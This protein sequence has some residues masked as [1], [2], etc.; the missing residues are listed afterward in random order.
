[1]DIRTLLG[2]SV[3]KLKNRGVSS[4][5]LD[6]ELLLAQ[7]LAKPKEY[8]HTYPE[9][10]ISKEKEKIFWTLIKKRSAFIPLAHL[11]GYKEFWGRNFSVG[12]G[13]LVPRPESELIIEEVLKNDFSSLPELNLIDVGT[14]SGCLIVTLS[15]FLEKHENISFWGID[16]HSTPLKYSR[17]NAHRHRQKNIK[18]VKGSLLS[19]FLKDPDK[20]KK[21]NIVVANLPYLT[22]RQLKEEKSI[23]KEPKKSLVS[24]NKG[25]K[26]YRKLFEQL[27]K[28]KKAK[29][30][31]GLRIYCEINPGQADDIKKMAS[32]ILKAEN[33]EIKK[34]L[35]GKERLLLVNWL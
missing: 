34:D 10:K 32:R 30:E 26:H 23:Q 2:K 6:S 5:E 18:L 1:M 29:P 24:P 7:I 4:P 35:S 14:G 13:V 12:K 21:F 19:Y 15:R 20:L 17:I 3:N 8:I 31:A 25:L 33:R 9:K 22:R 27:F 11:L 16:K 28:I